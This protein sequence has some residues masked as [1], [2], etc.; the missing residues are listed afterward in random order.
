MYTM[1]I[2]L[3]YCI[4]LRGCPHSDLFLHAK[5]EM[6]LFIVNYDINQKQHHHHNNYSI[7][8]IIIVIPLT[9]GKNIPS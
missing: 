1:K 3:R 8:A 9:T 4:L 5:S 6:L 7:S 2:S